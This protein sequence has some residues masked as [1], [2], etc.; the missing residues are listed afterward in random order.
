MKTTKNKTAYITFQ[1]GEYKFA[2]QAVHAHIIPCGSSLSTKKD[3]PTPKKIN[4]CG[5]NIPVVNLMKYAHL[6][7][8]EAFNSDSLLLVE[9]IIK[10]EIKTICFVIDKLLCADKFI[11]NSNI[12]PPMPVLQNF[13]GD[14]LL[15][16]IK[17]KKSFYILINIK[18]LIE[19]VVNKPQKY[20]FQF[21]RNQNLN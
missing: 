6:Q 1:L 15:G 18:E 12:L 21:T 5:K 19:Y 3:I 8:Y 4:Y 20:L 7:E 16:T 13:N 10:D 2:V 9:T 11:K 14:I 17:Y